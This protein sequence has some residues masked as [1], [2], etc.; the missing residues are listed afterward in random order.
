LDGEDTEPEEDK[1][2]EEKEKTSSLQPGGRYTSSPV[3]LTAQSSEGLHR[4]TSCE[5][6]YT[7]ARSEF[8]TQDSSEESFHSGYATPTES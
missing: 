6:N 7:D 2:E 5:S 4:A 3:F 8:S 1:H